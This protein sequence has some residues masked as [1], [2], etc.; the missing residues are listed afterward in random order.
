MGPRAIAACVGTPVS[1]SDHAP[2][3]IILVHKKTKNMQ[4]SQHYCEGRNCLQRP[5]QIFIR[6]CKYDF[7]TSLI[8]HFAAP[9]VALLFTL[10]TS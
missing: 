3:S 7:R 9:E 8:F 1:Y 2:N 10:C 6:G 5:K 4:A